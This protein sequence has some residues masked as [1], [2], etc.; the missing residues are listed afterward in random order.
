M[1]E[2]PINQYNITEVKYKLSETKTVTFKLNNFM[3]KDVDVEDTSKKIETAET[4]VKPENIVDKQ[5][6]IDRTI[7]DEHEAV[8][9]KKINDN[10]NK[11]KKA[12]RN[13]CKELMDK[14]DAVPYKVYEKIG[15]LHTFGKD[16][17][18]FINEPD[19]YVVND[20][21]ERAKQ[22]VPGMLKKVEAS[23]KIIEKDAKEDS[24][25]IKERVENSIGT[26]EPL[27][28][29]LANAPKERSYNEK[30]WVNKD[31]EK[32]KNV[33]S[34]TFKKARDKALETKLILEVEDERE[35]TE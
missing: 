26:N 8:K 16:E 14:L 27:S 4:I 15:E 6:A 35:A 2:L 32:C 28:D 3:L 18:I 23:K 1:L 13:R 12:D 25:I 22:K 17:G 10:F 7:I 30:E 29:E 31:L 24:K 11:L 21:R 34:D 19:P 20:E 33:V 9:E 5:Y